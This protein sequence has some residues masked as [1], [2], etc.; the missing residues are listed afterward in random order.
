MPPVVIADASPLIGLAK[1][2]RLDLLQRLYQEVL[3]PPAVHS[4]LQAGSQRPGGQELLRALDDGWLKVADPKDI[5]ST[6]SAL[7]RQ[8]LDAG[9]AE[10]IALALHCSAV[11]LVIDEQR[12]RAIAQR[13]GLRIAGSGAVLLAAKRLGHIESVAAELDALYQVGYRLSPKLRSQLTAMAGE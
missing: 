1:I 13:R 2:G 4:E 6:E 9:E 7:L 11:L 12:G 3:I 10:A 8:V 5:P